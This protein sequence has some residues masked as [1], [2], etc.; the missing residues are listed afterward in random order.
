[1]N[2][3]MGAHEGPTRRWRP[4][5]ARVF[6]SI[7]LLALSAC[8]TWHPVARFDGW[9]L[10]AEGGHDVDTPKFEAAVAPAFVAVREALGQIGRASCRARG[11]ISVVA[12]SLKKK[13]HA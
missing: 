10:Y 4:A 7:A 8:T 11:E 9:S 2:G 3:E 13:T 1:M 5:G 6:L 12:G